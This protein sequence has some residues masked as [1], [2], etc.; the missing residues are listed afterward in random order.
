MDIG[1]DGLAESVTNAFRQRRANAQQDYAIK[2]RDTFNAL[3][4]KYNSTPIEQRPALEQQMAIA[5]PEQTQNF[6]SLTQGQANQAKA[7][8]AAKAKDLA[9]KAQFVLASKSPKATLFANFPD[10]VN[11][12]RQN[13]M[14]VDSITDDEVRQVA[15]RA[16]EHYAPAAG[17]GPQQPIKMSAGETLVDPNTQQ[18]TYTAPPKPSDSAP[19]AVIGKDGKPV[20]VSHQDAVGKTPYEKPP[21]SGFGALSDTGQADNMAQM[22]ADGSMAMPTGR[23]LLTP[24]GQYLAKKVKDLNPS[25]SGA[26]Y[27]TQAAAL[28]AFTS[29]KE[30]TKIRSLNT[31]I[32]HMGS[33]DELSQALNN[34]DTQM[35]NR[36]ANTLSKEM[37][38]TAVT[39]FNTAKD[40]VA[41][42]VISAVVAGGGGQAEREEA[43]KSFNAANSPQQ[44]AEVT[45][46]YRDL[47]GGQLH[48]LSQ[49]YEQGTGRKDFQRFLTDKTIK[50]LG[51]GTDKP[52]QTETQAP[53][54][55]TGPNGQKIQLVNGQW[56][57]LNAK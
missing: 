36:V 35:F 47:L 43:A 27:P 4:S 52:Q 10:F 14:D 55:A 20:Y 56:V 6:L 17:M 8:E 38:G 29:G 15:Q 28:R 5:S 18:P 39:N 31:A 21:A 13:G 33:L 45:N 46:V 26:T 12:V 2:H 30:S 48:S 54:T 53:V 11:Q 40:L 25:F 34:K 44:L 49:Q 3:A 41:K 22:I 42:E 23:A 50:A 9:V 1:D 16:Y 57:P 51:N 24:L 19:T 37:G 32:A 7:Q